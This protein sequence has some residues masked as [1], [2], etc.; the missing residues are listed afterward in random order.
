MGELWTRGHDTGGELLGRQPWLQPTANRG[1]G[2]KDTS[3][4]L[5]TH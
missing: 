5:P 3:L 2:L 1:P 4:D